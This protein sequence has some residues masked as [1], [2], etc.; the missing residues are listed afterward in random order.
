[1][2]APLENCYAFGEESTLDQ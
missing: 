2:N 1:M